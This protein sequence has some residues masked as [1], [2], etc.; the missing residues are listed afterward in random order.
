M[1]WVKQ[2]QSVGDREIATFNE[3]VSEKGTKETDSKNKG[4][5]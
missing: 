2:R 4:E 3:K 5:N 1:R